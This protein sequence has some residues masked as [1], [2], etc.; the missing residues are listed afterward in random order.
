MGLRPRSSPPRGQSPWYR[1]QRSIALDVELLRRY[2]YTRADQPLG[3]EDLFDLYVYK[4]LVRSNNLLLLPRDVQH[5]ARRHR[6]DLPGQE[7][8]AVA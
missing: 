4:F 6:P 1:Y 8:Q 2:D 3:L 5:L 7:P